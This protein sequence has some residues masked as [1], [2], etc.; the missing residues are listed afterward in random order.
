VPVVGDSRVKLGPFSAGV[1]GDVQ[2]FRVL[3]LG[4]LPAV[5]AGR[6][7]HNVADVLDGLFDLALWYL[8]VLLVVWL[9]VLQVRF[10]FADAEAFQLVLNPRAVF[11]QVCFRTVVELL[12]PRVRERRIIENVLQPERFADVVRALQVVFEFEVRAAGEAAVDVRLCDCQRVFVPFPFKEVFLFDD[13]ARIVGDDV[14]EN[15]FCEGPVA[16]R[17][18]RRPFDV[19]GLNDGDLG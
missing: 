5:K 1:D 15:S 18:P 17:R 6:A 16:C 10:Y 19:G 7:E 12:S 2:E 14:C 13:R 11:L 3:V 4:P 8:R 9:F